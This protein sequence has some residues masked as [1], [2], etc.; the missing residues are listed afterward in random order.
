MGHRRG[1]DPASLDMAAALMVT[2][3]QGALGQ[4]GRSWKGLKELSV[5]T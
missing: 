4:V 5:R 1:L 3:I 2:L